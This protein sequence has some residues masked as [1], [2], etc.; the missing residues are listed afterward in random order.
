L[1]LLNWFNNL[2]LKH[3]FLLGF[4]S[5]ILL[6]VGN[7]LVGTWALQNVATDG[8]ELS[9][10]AF[11]RAV[12]MAKIQA[13]MRDARFNALR[14][15]LATDKDV[16]ES[17]EMTMEQT[18]GAVE[19]AY[20]D[21]NKLARSAEDKAKVG[22]LETAWG[23]HVEY[24]RQT[25][26]LVREGRQ[27]EA[28]EVMDGESKSH[29][30]NDVTSAADEVIAFNEA[31]ARTLDRRLES[32]E[33][34]AQRIVLGFVL[35]GVLAGAGYAFV[36]WSYLTRTLDKVR[37]GLTSLSEHC[38]PGLDRG[39]QALATG[40]LTQRV[41][42][43]T[44]PTGVQSKDEIGV[45]AQ[46]FD[47]LLIMVQRTIDSY[48]RSME[49]LGQALSEVNAS[50]QHVALTSA[51]V[52]LAMQQSGTA[53]SE[54]AQG[55][56]KLAGNAEEAMRVVESLFGAIGQVSAGSGEQ[57]KALDDTEGRLQLAANAVSTVAGASDEMGRLAT[58]G[59]EAVSAA[60]DAMSRI[61]AQVNVAT[62]RAQALHAKSDQI[63]NIIRTIQGIAEQTNLLAL[64]AAIEAARAGEHGRGFAVVADEVRK[65]AEQASVA[66]REIGGLI[67]EVR[68]T[69]GETVEAVR[70]ADRQVAEGAERSG[71]AGALLV[72]IVAAAEGVLAQAKTVA[73]LTTQ[74]SRSMG[75]VR[76][77]ARTNEALVGQMTNDANRVST[78]MTGVA[79]VSEESAAGA[80]ELSASIEEVSAA[81][82]ELN[83]MA[84]QLRSIVGRFR[85][86]A[87]L[88]NERPDLRL[89]A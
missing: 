87:E 62:D 16:A 56:S 80:Q 78:S 49:K 84:G 2:K 47:G 22:A 88:A 33:T 86:D 64:N 35:F 74:A 31:R 21:Y 48:N 17:N 41:K 29:F 32:S 69:V 39:V 14:I 37:M 40:D 58:S 71:Q 72:Q 7:A 6:S 19:S 24:L 12:A 57:R 15:S 79:A 65:L 10:Y 5:F 20:R 50:A 42:T 27:T 38:V 44:D 70:D 26:T 23:R 36:L 68:E 25:A 83:E 34:T 28:R 60:G 89:A 43:Y 85:F 8:H 75:H 53:S 67:T 76:D 52:A 9:Q 54:I 3:K 66:T 1:A 46:T 51:N 30:L 61:R 82:E 45:M 59:N 4:V 11:P 13:G 55:S 73:D 63:G 77:V 18:L 81:T